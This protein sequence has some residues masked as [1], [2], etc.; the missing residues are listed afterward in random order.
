MDPSD[1]RTLVQNATKSLSA[2]QQKKL[3]AVL[4]DPRKLK[5]LQSRI[6]DDELNGLRQNISD[7]SALGAFLADGDIQKRIN[8]IL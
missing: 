3:K 2:A 5:A 6:S 1:L 4:D 8:E 7:P